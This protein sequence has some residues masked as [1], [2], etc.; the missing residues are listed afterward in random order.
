MNK[1]LNLYEI[2]SYNDLIAAL[3]CDDI[4]LHNRILSFYHRL[5]S[6]VYY[7]KAT[8]FFYQKNDKGLYEKH[9]SISMN[10]KNAP[11]KIEEYDEIYC[12]YDDSLP[13]LDQE[14]Q[15]ILRASDFFDKDERKNNR[16]W[17]EYLVPNNCIY[18]IEG[19]IKIDSDSGL[20]A[21][22]ALFRGKEKKDFTDLEVYLIKLM[23]PHFTNIFKNY[24][25]D[26]TERDIFF[27][28]ENYN[29]IGLTMLDGQ[30]NII[31]SNHA[32]NTIVE[33]YSDLT[34]TKKVQELCINLSKS[35]LNILEYKIDEAAL[36]FE[37]SRFSSITRPEGCK[38]A[39]SC[40]LYDLSHF[41]SIILDLAKEQY[42]LSEREFEILQALLKGKSNEQIAEELYL[43]FHTVKKY[44][45]SIY[46]KMDINSQKQIYNKLKLL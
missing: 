7:D 5:M 9:S 28:L 25:T 1:E 30:Y 4:P 19:N 23:Q 31:N 20:R 18:S 33:K 17:R 27:M 2:E 16:Y 8:I 11:V 37:V 29:C 22:I 39:Y 44:L 41:S 21:G 46:E 35:E 3:Y 32:F 40:L 13:I 45:A 6:I 14:N 36:F 38:G 24:S 43:S 15:I 42:Q 26:T 12:K 10:W 34:I